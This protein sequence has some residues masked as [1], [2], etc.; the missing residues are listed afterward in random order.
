MSPFLLDP[1]LRGHEIGSAPWFE[2][3]AGMIRR[4]P[5]IRECYDLWY[6]SLLADAGSVPGAGGVI[7][8][9]GSGLS[10]IK[11]LDPDVITSDVTPGRVDLVFD[12][13]RLPFRDGSVR[14]LFLTHVFHHIPDVAAFLREAERVLVPGGVVS[15]VDVTH[16]PF[17]RFF[18]SSVHP[19]PYNERSAEWTFPEGHTMLD[20]N[21]AL[22]W[23]V[24][25]R[26]RERFDREFPR[27]ALE[28][29]RFLPWFGYLLSGGVNLRSLF[30]AALLGVVRTLD[31]W[32]RPLDPIFAIHWQITVRK[33]L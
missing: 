24:F 9:L 23:I 17:G 6:R 14:A 8:E 1:G 15:M 19:E 18:F 12:G 27:L 29:F 2:A 28:K 13:R 16:T 4:K 5:L 33:R 25:V 30:P 10:Y 26:D 31:R 22:T 32:L 7:V 20:S 3:Q 11:E 21:Q